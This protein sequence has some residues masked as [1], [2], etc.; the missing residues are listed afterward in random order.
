M[1]FDEFVDLLASYDPEVA[2]T[3]LTLRE[4]L[5]ASHPEFEEKVYH[6]WRGL[7]FHHPEAG[8]VCAIFPRSKSVYLSFERGIRL[9]D[10]EGRLV[11]AGKMVRS[12]EFTPS[13]EIDGL[14]FY[15]DA[16]IELA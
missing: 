14:D 12:L 6:G 10:P 13:D 16:A 9:P 1:E 11:G 5:R 3:A 15:L 2:E 8:Y 7:G 4:R